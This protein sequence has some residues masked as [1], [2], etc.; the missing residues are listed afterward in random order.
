MVSDWT[1]A[2][3]NSVVGTRRDDF[4]E[5]DEIERKRRM[6]G[7]ECCFGWLTERAVSS[8]Q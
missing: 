8:S 2:G 1:A 3:N 6:S 5:K 4:Q 7:D